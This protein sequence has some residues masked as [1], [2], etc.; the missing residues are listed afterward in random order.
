M[1]LFLSSYVNKV[2]KKG[3]V[4][5]PSSF[6]AV[7]TGEG[8]ADVVLFKSLQHDALEGCSL[9]HLE[10]LSASLDKLNLAPEIYELVEGTIFGGSSACP[11][12]GDGRIILPAALAS[13]VGIEDE[14]AFVGKRRTFQIWNPR[15][16]AAYEAR[17]RDSAR[18]HNISLSKI[19]AEASRANGGEA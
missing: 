16:F 1:S 17:A 19:I 2:D 14:A 3:R 15:A 12:D 4:S 7:I 9:K 6:R 11:I 8:S 13:A 5:V 10:I 18:A